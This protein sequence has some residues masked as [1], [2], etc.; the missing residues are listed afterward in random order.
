MQG[1]AWAIAH[2]AKYDDDFNLGLSL[3]A[4][5]EVHECSAWVPKT[6]S[7]FQLCRMKTTRVA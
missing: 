7:Y 1:R 6:F 4:Q 2:L 3:V 5:D